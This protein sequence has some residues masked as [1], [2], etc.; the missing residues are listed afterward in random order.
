MILTNIVVGPLCY[1]LHGLAGEPA[2]QL[3]AQLRVRG[4]SSAQQLLAPSVALRQTSVLQE[5]FELFADKC[6]EKGKR[7]DSCPTPY[8]IH[9]R[10]GQDKWKKRQ[11]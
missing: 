7:S 9:L 6:E 5:Y 4:M 10:S 2:M 3:F 11:F 8:H 1:S